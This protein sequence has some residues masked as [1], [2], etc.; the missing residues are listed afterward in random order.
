[1]Q[2]AESSQALEAA[3]RLSEQIDAKEEIIAYLKSECKWAGQKF[4]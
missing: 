2:L 4:Y 1:M 3:S